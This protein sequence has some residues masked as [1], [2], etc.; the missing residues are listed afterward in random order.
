MERFADYYRELP[1][2]DQ[3]Q[4]D[5]RY[6]FENGSYSY[7]DAIVLYCMIRHVA[8]KRIVEVGSGYSSC[9]MI[10][11]NERYFNN[12]IR[13]TFVEPYPDLLLSITSHEDRERFELRKER[14]QDAG[15]ELFRALEAGDILFIDSTHVSK[16]NS[17]VNHIFFG[18]LPCLN[19]GVY[20]HFH[21]IFY[22]F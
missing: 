19:S 14:L 15:L 2:K 13:L 21:D 9:L 11:T 16:I 17:D 6:Y 18:I 12:Q 3:K 4:Q 20:I 7:S 8:P 5:M 1:F 22:P 10:D